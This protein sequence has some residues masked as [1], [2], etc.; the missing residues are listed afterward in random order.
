[1]PKIS[2]VVETFLLPDD[3]TLEDLAESVQLLADVPF[4]L[5]WAGDMSESC[6]MVKLNRIGCRDKYDDA[7]ADEGFLE[8][9]PSEEEEEAQRDQEP[10]YQKPKPKMFSGPVPRPPSRGS[11][12]KQFAEPRPPSGPPPE[13]AEA[14]RFRRPDSRAEQ[15]V[16][17]RIKPAGEQ[18]GDHRGSRSSSSQGPCHVCGKVRSEHANK[19]F[20][21]RKPAR[22]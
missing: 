8:A 12:A 5:T 18:P 15:P 2:K 1:M 14:P 20:C 11:V 22:R 6:T 10:L 3:T 17:K 13:P 4:S 19:K 21:E 9:A 16:F 7:V